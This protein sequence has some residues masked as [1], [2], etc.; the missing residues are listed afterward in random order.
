MA[1]V[2]G[3][4]Y[5]EETESGS[6]KRNGRNDAAMTSFRTFILHYFVSFIVALHRLVFYDT[7]GPSLQLV[8]TERERVFAAD[9]LLEG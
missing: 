4:A 9:V 6:R 7:F 8:D 3:E 2:G 5:E 1:R